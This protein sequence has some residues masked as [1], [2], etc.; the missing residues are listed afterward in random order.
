M[1]HLASGGYAGLFVAAVLAAT[2]L[3]GSSEAALV[4]LAL[5]G[6]HSMPGLLLVATVGNTLGSAANWA[7][8]RWLAQYAG[9]RWFPVSH[10]RLD[11]AT[12][13]FR[14]YGA[15]SLLFAWVPIVGDPL[16]AAA[17]ALRMPFLPFI[18]LVAAGKAARYAL[19][20]IALDLARR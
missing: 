9:R 18:V 10:A 14:R 13:W 8:G 7:A 15:W 4:A 16:T 5:A 20:L 19:L 1:E 6:Q 12:A 11:Q 3:P 17:G 2:L